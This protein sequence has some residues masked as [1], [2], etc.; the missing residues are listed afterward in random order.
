MGE[1]TR[2]SLKPVR[3]PSPRPP[4]YVPGK[5]IRTAAVLG[6]VISACLGMASG[7]LG[8]YCYYSS[9]LRSIAHSVG[10]WLL[11]ALG[12]AAGRSLGRAI[13]QSS[14]VLIFAVPTFYISK[15]VVFDSY[16][17]DLANMV[18]WAVAAATGGVGLGVIGHFM[19]R[20]DWSG[21]AATAAASGLLLGDAYV[22]IHNYSF[23]AAARVDVLG[24]ALVLIFCCRSIVHLGRT[25]LMIIPMTVVGYGLVSAPNWIQQILIE[26]L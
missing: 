2:T 10:L 19:V 12:C 4:A 3:R 11:V 24:A 21:A 5:P 8:A 16:S 14:L 18:L 6:C 7:L 1:R 23:D 26:G 13:S 15:H 20:Q 17:V 22:R 9:N 25:I